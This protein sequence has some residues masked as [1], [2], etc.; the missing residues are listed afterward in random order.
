MTE[1]PLVEVTLA[2]PPEL[3]DVS[4][5]PPTG[6]DWLREMNSVYFAAIIIATIA[7]FAVVVMAVVHLYF[8]HYY[9]GN[10]PVQDNLYYLALLFP[11][12]FF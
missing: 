7:V 12:V 11:V 3:F 8:I 5:M 4:K 9:I 1:S 2:R 6:A 10:E